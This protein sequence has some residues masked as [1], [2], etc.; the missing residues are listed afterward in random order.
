MVGDPIIN[1]VPPVAAKAGGAA[2]KMP[3]AKLIELFLRMFL[4]A[5]I[6]KG[7]TDAYVPTITEHTTEQV[8][9]SINAELDL[10]LHTALQEIT[11]PYV[12][13]TV[14]RTV[15]RALTWSLTESLSHAITTNVLLLL[16]KLLVPDGLDAVTEH[17]TGTIAHA[18][19][20]SVTHALTRAPAADYY[21]HFCRYG[22]NYYSESYSLLRLSQPTSFSP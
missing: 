21:C 19:A 9:D 13:R 8:V 3:M 15:T 4:V 18:V 14:A 12:N 10:A 20:P 2:G 6:L 1:A 7:L 17:L 11:P 16:A 22:L 5:P